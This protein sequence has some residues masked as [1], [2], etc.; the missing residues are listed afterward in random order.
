MLVCCVSQRG[1]GSARQ[2]PRFPIFVA[3]KDDGSE[4]RLSRWPA[5]FLLRLI[6]L[7]SRQGGRGGAPAAPRGGAT[8]HIQLPS[9]SADT[10]LPPLRLRRRT[11]YGD[12]ARLHDPPQPRST[13]LIPKFNLQHATFTAGHCPVRNR[14]SLRRE[15]IPRLLDKVS[16]AQKF[17]K[18]DREP[19]S[20]EWLKTRG[21]TLER[22][23]PHR[24]P[25]AQHAEGQEK[26]FV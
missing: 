20:T 25:R 22:S 5:R 1:G 11:R 3:L 17:H 14:Q 15:A 26:F 12:C 8:G 23:H 24:D 21:E 4:W 7:P 10:A 16:G 18:F 19:G 9:S 13:C 2:P 6:Q